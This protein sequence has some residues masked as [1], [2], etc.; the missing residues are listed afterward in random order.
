LYPDS[1][2]GL[3]IIANFLPDFLSIGKVTSKSLVTVK[4]LPLKLFLNLVP[5][6]INFASKGES[7]FNLVLSLFSFNLK[8]PPFGHIHAR[9]DIGDRGYLYDTAY[10]VPPPTPLYNII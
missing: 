1:N 7:S 2:S 3:Y 5:F 6:F 9:M 4:I 8:T 10:G